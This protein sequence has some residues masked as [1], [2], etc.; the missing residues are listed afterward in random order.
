M[1]EQP[2]V[3]IVDDDPSQ[4]AFALSFAQYGV[5]ARHVLPGDLDLSDLRCS[6][7]VLIDEFIEDWPQRDPVRDKVG[8]YVRDGIALCGVLRSSVD[9]RGPDPNSTPK[10]KS[11]AFVLRTGHLDQLAAGTPA[12]VRPMAVASRHDLEWV[13]EKKSVGAGELA[14][15]AKAVAALPTNWPAEPISWL[16]L[17]DQPWKATALAQIEQCRPPWTVLAESS[18]GRR[19]LSWF[20]QRILPFPTF[21]VDDHRAASYLGLRPSAL[22]E[23]LG[24]RSSLTEA[25]TSAVYT[26]QLA[27]FAGRRWWRA[28]IAAVKNLAQEKSAGRMADEIS[29]A[30]IELHGSG[31]EVLGLKHPVFQIDSN[32]MLVSQPI[33]ITDAVRLQPDDWPSYADDPWL[34]GSLVDSETDLAKL[35]VLDDRVDTANDDE[36]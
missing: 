8:L 28:G 24:G 35:I 19:W 10:P 14:S 36:G 27:D 13:V 17:N 1:T 5:R 33:E 16:G 7:L 32:Y 23:I 31:L 15:L 2:L 9:N 12:F 21:L 4:E 20:L 11:V 34:A 30:V 22:D 25:L 26:G 18:A 6:S 29:R 3:L